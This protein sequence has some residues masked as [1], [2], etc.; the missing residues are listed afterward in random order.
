[1]STVKLSIVIPIFNEENTIRLLYESITKYLSSFEY[2]LIFINDGSLD[3]TK[4]EIIKINDKHVKLINFSRNFGQSSALKAGIDYASGDY[5]ITMD[6]DMQNDPSDIPMMVQKA[7]KEDYDLVAG[8]RAN[9]KDGALLRK[10]PSKI[11]NRLIKKTTKTDFKDLGCALKVIKADMAKKLG[12]YGELHRFISILAVFE[13][14]R[15]TQVNVK[16]HER[17][18]GKSKYGLDRTFKVLC[19]LFLMLF[20]KKYIQRPIHL[21]GKYGAIMSILGIL[22][23]L[24]LVGVKLILNQDIG[25]RPLLFLGGLL[26][27]SGFQ[28]ITVGLVAELQ[29]RTYFES[30][31]KKPYN[32]KSLF[33]GGDKV[34]L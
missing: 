21:F 20:L 32:I 22:I 13:G 16:H 15:F 2:E 11:A 23:N 29:M 4:N 9:R 28:L 3:E 31:E 26:I 1:M 19:D 24:Y 18:F 14:A 6:G 33:I 34:N 30:Q 5:I 8:V 10:I 27:T 17:K 7:I 12:I 25:N